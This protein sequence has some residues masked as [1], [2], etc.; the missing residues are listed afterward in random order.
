MQSM[1]MGK[2][3]VLSVRHWIRAL[4]L[5]ICVDNKEQIYQLTPLAEQ[6]FTHKNGRAAYDEYLDKIGTIWLLHWLLQSI[7]TR[8]AEL[9]ASRFLFNYFNGIKV[10]KEF[11]ANEIKDALTNHEKELTE[12]TLNKD[13]DCLLQMYA[14]KSLQSKKINED[15][16]ASPFTELGLLKQEDARSYLAELSRRPSLPVEVF[17]YALIDYMQRKHQESKVNTLSF[18]ALLNDVGSPGRVF[19]LSAAGLSDKLDRVETLTEG[20][21]AWTDTQGLRQVQHCFE[22][23][24]NIKADQYLKHYY[25]PEGK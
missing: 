3:M 16:F 15:S 22:D 19:R 23:I 8:N 11:L 6:L 12:E 7:D 4:N 25:Q 9:N 13:I 24:N 14:H 10:K 18:E 5:V 21:I 20:K 17:T 1:G 2:N